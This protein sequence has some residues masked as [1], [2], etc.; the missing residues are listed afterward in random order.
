MSE[1]NSLEHQ[2][3][4]VWDCTGLEYLADITADEQ[5]RMWA[6]LQG[7]ES[8]AHSYANPQHLILRARANPQRHYEIYVFS[9]TEGITKDDIQEMFDNSP[10][11]AADTIRRVGRCIYSDRA[12]QKV[13]IR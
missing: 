8:P 2:F 6:K 4:A 11:T 3:L 12:E 10:Q 9:A 13:A 7:N 5:R 1:E